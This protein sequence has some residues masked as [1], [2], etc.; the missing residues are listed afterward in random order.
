L[1][2]RTHFSPLHKVLVPF[3]EYVFVSEDTPAAIKEGGLPAY[4]DILG[5]LTRARRGSEA[6]VEALIP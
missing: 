3:I 2:D 4:R 1:S 5:I 6:M